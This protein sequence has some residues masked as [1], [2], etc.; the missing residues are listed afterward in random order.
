VT[1]ASGSHILCFDYFFLLKSERNFTIHKP[2]NDNI[3]QLQSQMKIHILTAIPCHQKCQSKI[4][5]NSTVTWQRTPK[6]SVQKS[7]PNQSLKNISQ[8]AKNVKVA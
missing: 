4:Y 2:S 1:G 6:K 3:S 5:E 8:K 7:H